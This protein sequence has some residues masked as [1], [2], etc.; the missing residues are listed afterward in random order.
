MSNYMA[1]TQHNYMTSTEAYAEAQKIIDENPTGIVVAILA[2][3]ILRE[4][5]HEKDRPEGW[6]YA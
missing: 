6:V 3:Y 1:S 5:K 2:G 4:D